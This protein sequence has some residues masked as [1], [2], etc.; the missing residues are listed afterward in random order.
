[1]T[2]GSSVTDAVIGLFVS[3]R[4][5]WMGVDAE[6]LAQ[7]AAAGLAGLFAG[8]SAFMSVAQHPALLRAK[9]VEFQA[10]F[11]RRMYFYAARVQAPLALG[12]GISSMFVSYTQWQAQEGGEAGGGMPQLW[13]LSG[14]VIAGVVPFT[15]IK[16]LALNRE[17][18]DPRRCRAKG[19]RW[20]HEKLVRWGRLHAF[21]AGASV[22]A[23]TGML[24]AMAC[25]DRRVVVVVSSV[26]VVAT[27]L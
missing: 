13:L 12:S 9:R 4:C 24:V 27:R 3:G 15:M 5:A 26:D 17:L 19:S 16:M 21:R 2:G 23:F 6:A 22:L 1:M 20:M 7:V 25:A 8:A 10:P 18:L 14:C 11:F